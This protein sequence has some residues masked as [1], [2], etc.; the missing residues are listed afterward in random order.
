MKNKERKGRHLLTLYAHN[1]P[2]DGQFL[3]GFVLERTH[4]GLF[5]EKVGGAPTNMQALITASFARIQKTDQVAI[6][7]EEVVGEQVYV[8]HIYQSKQP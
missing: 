4:Q 3:A 2:K 1:P 5:R 7:V 6:L 8:N